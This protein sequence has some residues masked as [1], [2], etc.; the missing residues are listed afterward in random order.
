MYTAI[1][2][3]VPVIAVAVSGKGYD[4]ATATNLLQHLDT[5]LGGV[6]PGAPKTLRDEGVDLIDVA[7]KLSVVLPK[8]IS[9]PFNS[10]ASERLI[11]SAIL[12]IVDAVN[13]A[14]PLPAPTGRDAW[15]AKRGT[16]P[17]VNRTQHEH[18]G[19]S[20]STGAKSESPASSSAPAPAAAATVGGL[21]TVPLDVPDLPDVLSGRPDVATGIRDSLLGKGAS[22]AVSISSTVSSK[23]AAHGQGGVGKT[24]MA[25]LAVND[26]AVRAAFECIGWVSVGQTPVILEMQRTLFDQLTGDGM[27]VKAGATAA[28]Q[29][30]DLQAACV[31]KCWLVVLDDVWEK[32]HEQMLNCIDPA[33][34]SKLLVTTRIRGLLQGCEELSLNLMGSDESVDLLLRTGQVKGQNKT[35]Q[36][37]AAIIAELCDNLPLYLSICG[38]MILGYDND[39]AWQTELAAMLSEDRVGLLD[40]GSG[41]RRQR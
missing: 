1:E 11:S 15:L 7:F 32:D 31:G 6:N 10:S 22:S 16:G 4:F 24:T 27:K 21:A 14:A 35:A 41:D 36:A 25:V 18:G 38:G 17:V 12:D 29:L 34:R 23:V 19:A 3:G 33:S 40:D 9:L 2:A 20:A 5:R 37:A 30:E 8:I 28:S 39:P 13:D 26:P